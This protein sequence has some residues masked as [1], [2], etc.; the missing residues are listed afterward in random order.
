MYNT[1]II[2]IIII[3][4]IIIIIMV[5]IPEKIKYTSYVTNSTFDKK[6]HISN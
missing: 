1:I 6:D 5:F 4:I 3:I 2:M